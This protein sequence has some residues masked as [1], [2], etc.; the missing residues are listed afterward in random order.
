MYWIEYFK[1]DLANNLTE[2]VDDRGTVR[3]DGRNS[4]QTMKN[5]AVRFN[6]YRRPIYEAYQIIKGDSLLRARPITAV[7]SLR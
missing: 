6:G 4:L 7:I 3:L 1:R 2:A 5:D